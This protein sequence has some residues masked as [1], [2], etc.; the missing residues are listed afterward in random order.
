MR[1]RPVSGF[2]AIPRPGGE[3]GLVTGT[4]PGTRAE[5]RARAL[6]ALNSAGLARRARENVSRDPHRHPGPFLQHRRPLFYPNNR[7]FFEGLPPSQLQIP[8]IGD[9]TNPSDIA[10]I[11]N[12]EAFFNTMVVNGVTWPTLEVAP[13]LTASAC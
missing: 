5:W 8:F 6:P 1:D 12:P 13:A 9:A 11:W 4:L 10:P 2:C 3:T 7:A